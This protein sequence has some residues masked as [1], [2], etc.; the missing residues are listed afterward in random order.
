MWAQ[1][2]PHKTKLPNIKSSPLS[3]TEKPSTWRQ[4]TT[5]NNFYEF[6]IDKGDASRNAKN[7]RT[8]P[9]TVSVEGLVKKASPTR[10]M[11]F[12]KSSRSR[13]GS[14]ACAVWRVGRWLFHT[15]QRVR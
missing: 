4:I 14:T 11:T 5:Y 7:F 10:S 8:Q 1:E 2:A 6:G 12:S 9:W 15:L 3:T 13:T